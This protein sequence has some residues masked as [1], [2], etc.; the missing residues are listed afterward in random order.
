MKKVKT[1]TAIVLLFACVAANVAV[2]CSDARADKSVDDEKVFSVG[3][4]IKDSNGEVIGCDCPLAQ[5]A[6]VC[7][8]RPMF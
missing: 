5:G 4:K 6:C 2:L 8:T 7:K 3:N 1:I